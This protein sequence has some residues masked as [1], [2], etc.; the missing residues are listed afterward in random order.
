MLIP[1]SGIP[2]HS[3]HGLNPALFNCYLCGEE[4]GILIPGARTQKFKEAG[5]C[6][7]DGK[8]H[9]SIGCIDRNPCDKCKEYMKM[10]IIVISVKDGESGDNPYRT[11]GW[12]VVKD[13]VFKEIM[14]AEDPVFISIMKRRV[15]FIEDKV[16]EMIGLPEVKVRQAE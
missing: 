16:W 7:P 6:D 3:A 10:G 12:C 13:R 14:D 4:M 5:L 11:G 2:L 8:M 15:A 9:R 1:N